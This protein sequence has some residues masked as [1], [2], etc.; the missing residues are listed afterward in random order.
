[1]A[2]AL[3]ITEV[4]LRQWQSRQGRRRGRAGRPEAI[5]AVARTQIRSCYLAHYRQWGPQVLAIWSAR[6]GL[7]RWSPSTIAR[8]IADLRAPADEPLPARRIEVTHSGVM[9]SEDGTDFGR[10]R[11][12]RE[13]LVV[14]DEHSR[15]KLNWRLARG[16]A[17]ESHAVE[18]LEKAFREHGPP[19]VL[20]HD[21][22]SIFHG[23]RMRRLLEQWKVLDLTGPGYWPR[24]NGKK[25]RSMRDIKS[26]ER[27]LKK[28]GVGVSLAERIDLAMDDLNEER[29]RP[30][31]N[32]RTAREVFE[33]EQV[34]LVDR[35]ALAKEVRD[36]TR[37]LHA[38]ARSRH[39][40][41]AA[42]RH[43]VEMV[44]SRHGFLREKEDSVN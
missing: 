40:R 1:M 31:L 2:A 42:R 15:L 38:R 37:R 21:G 35:D 11:T 3:G 12:K 16:A 7:G 13:L 33:A 32:G 10:G 14:Q 41:R 28:H 25:E 18:N 17:R 36:E 22:D 39:E 6:E 23:Q 4:A 5:P 44:L 19:L 20:K 29:P 24:Y 34:D 43:A 8:A 30:M 26:M 27:A 9:W